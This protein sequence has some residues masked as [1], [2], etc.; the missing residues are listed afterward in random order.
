MAG[1][2]RFSLKAKIPAAKP[3]WS[4]KVIV[5]RPI[6]LKSIVNR[7]RPSVEHNGTM[8]AASRRDDKIHR[9]D[10]LSNIGLVR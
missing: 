9:F 7:P 10:G 3:C 4:H 6:A 2:M 1:N 8:V 5:P